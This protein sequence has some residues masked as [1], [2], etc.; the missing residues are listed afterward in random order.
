M[1]HTKFLENIEQK[2]KANPQ[3]IIF[4]EAALDIRVLTGA[5]KAAKQGICYSVLIGNPNHIQQLCSENNLS[6]P[7]SCNIVP[8]NTQ[9][10][11][12]R[13]LTETLLAKRAHKGLKAKEAT[14]LLANPHYFGTLLLETENGQGIVAGAV[15]TTAETFRPVFQII[16][17]K[18]KFH[19]ASSFFFMIKNERLLLFA[20]CAINIQPDSQTLAEIAIDTAETAKLFNI[21][22][23]VAFLSFSTYGSAKAEPVLKV[24]EALKIAKAKAPH[25]ILDGEMQVDAALVPEVAQL[26][27]PHSSLK[28]DANVLIFP[29]LQSGNIAYKLVQRLGKFRAIGPIVQGLRKPVNDLSRGC[30][31]EDVIQISAITSLQAQNLA[32]GI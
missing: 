21:Q 13:F 26:K 29:D 19:H 14:E 1:P 8:I 24:Q 25:L 22:P 9:D 20:D 6:L 16:K 15:S 17:T 31:I 4:P 3:K 5:I 27:C 7:D 2:A 18:E 11:Q 28:G 12:G 30:S 32:F 23:K 10:A